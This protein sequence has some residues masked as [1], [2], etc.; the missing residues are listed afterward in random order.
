ADA[1][2]QGR[3]DRIK[4]LH[5]LGIAADHQAVAAL[6]APHAP[7]R[8]DIEIVDAL[9]LELARAAYVVF[10]V[11]VAAVDDGVARTHQ[12]AELHN[13]LLGDLACGQH[14]PDGAWAFA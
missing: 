4:T 5:A 6:Q 1:R 8:A 13:R 2:R 7:R 12:P 14:D 11:G 3:E 9:G 10:E